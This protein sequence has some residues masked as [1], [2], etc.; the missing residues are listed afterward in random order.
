[1]RARC[2]LT[3]LLKCLACPMS[4]SRPCQ[5]RS[6]ASSQSKLLPLFLP[7]LDTAVCSLLVTLTLTHAMAAWLL[8]VWLLISSWTTVHVLSIALLLAF[9]LDCWI[10]SCSRL[11]FPFDLYSSLHILLSSFSPNPSTA[12]SKRKVELDEDG[13]PRKRANTGLNKPKP[14]SADMA[15]FLG[16][17]E[18]SRPQVHEHAFT[19][20]TSPIINQQRNQNLQA[21]L[22]S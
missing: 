12:R 3:T 8:L 17:S 14:V 18:S 19:L 2:C 21:W 7:S 9:S 6:A 10:L 22:R 13:K 11:A 5:G 15:A 16:K 4:T 20:H 1:M